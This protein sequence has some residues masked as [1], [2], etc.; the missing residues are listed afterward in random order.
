MPSK[1]KSKGNGFEREVC[2]YL[3]ELTDLNFT[4]VPNSGA[5]LGGANQVRVGNMTDAQT[6]IFDGDIITPDEWKDWSLE[7]KFYKDIAWKKLFQPEGVAQL[8]GWIEQ[9]KVTSKPYWLLIFKINNCGAY[10]V[11]D[12]KIVRAFG[13]KKPSC[14]MTYRKDYLVM[15]MKT[16]LST[17][18]KR[19]TNG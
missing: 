17:N 16:F 18:H 3:N 11:L 7:C 10:C 4:R 9:A 1:S 2:K 8:N 19:I 5:F 15:D 13:F 6:Q 12:K 14:V